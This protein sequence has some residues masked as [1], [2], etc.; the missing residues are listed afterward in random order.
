MSFKIGIVTTTVREPRKSLIIANWVLENANARLD[1]DIAYEVVDLQD[2][3]LP[4]FGTAVGQIDNDRIKRWQNKFAELDAYLFIVAE[5]NRAPT[6][7]FKNALDFLMSELNNKVVGYVGYGGLGAA[8]AI[9]HLRGINAEQELATVR[10]TV[11]LLLASD[12]KD[13][14]V[15]DKLYLKKSLDNVLNQVLLWGKALK[16]TR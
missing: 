15:V 9:Q 12:F 3:N 11:N 7:V 8:R 1:K 13:N 5:Y 2:Y 6:G 16:A 10:G 4:M 14:N